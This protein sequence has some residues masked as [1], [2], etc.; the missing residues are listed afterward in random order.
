MTSLITS[1]V[2]GCGPPVIAQSPHPR[3]LLSAGASFSRGV[4]T[5]AGGN[6]DNAQVHINILDQPVIADKRNHFVVSGLDLTPET[7][8]MNG[9]QAEALKVEDREPR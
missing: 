7:A 8:L 6:L 1:L 9:G 4:A 3:S 2:T 5:T